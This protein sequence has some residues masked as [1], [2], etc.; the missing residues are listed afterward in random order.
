MLHHAVDE[1][2]NGGG[3]PAWKEEEAA[4]FSLVPFAVCCWRSGSLHPP[5]RPVR[6]GTTTRTR[7]VIIHFVW[8]LKG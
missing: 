2:E 6:D 8:V 4:L 5:A 7:L 1:V 3:L